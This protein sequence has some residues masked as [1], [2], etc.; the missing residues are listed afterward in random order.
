MKPLVSV[1]IPNYNYARF[2]PQ[3]IDCVLGQ[4]YDNVE[5]IILDD[6]S[7]DNSRDVIETYRNYPK[8]KH[9]VFNEKNSG[10]TFR[11]WNRGFELAQ[12]DYIW[13]AECDDYAD[14]HFL[15]K[16]MARMVE[17]NSLKVGFSN[18]YWVTPESTFINKDY[19][20]SQPSKIY[21]GRKFIRQHLLKENFIY[22]ASMA[23]F[24]RDA[25]AGVNMVEVSSYRS[26]GDKLFWSMLAGQGKVI[27]VCEP[28]N[29][30]RIHN[31]KVTTG[32]LSDGT[33]FREEHRFFNRNI[34]E[35]FV[36][37]RNRY[38]VAAYFVDYVRRMKDSMV[39]EAVYNEC[40]HLWEKEKDICGNKELPLLYRW[41]HSIIRIR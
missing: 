1:I 23:V 33:L 8:V 13:I 24:R 15:E 32:A 20:I 12:G 2:L 16:I 7:T 31:N 9:L 39:S 3:R 27:F 36:T 37:W 10:S 6:C 5:L 34:R 26:C 40:L 18:S 25:L 21:E 28:L 14:V 17:D 41:Y 30:F 22:N 38:G 19:T 35:G 4:T 29:Y 11:Q